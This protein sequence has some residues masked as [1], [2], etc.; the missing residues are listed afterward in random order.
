MRVMSLVR[1]LFTE[2]PAKNIESKM[3]STLK[4]CFIFWAFTFSTFFLII[5]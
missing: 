5:L 1:K 4:T 3:T 2:M